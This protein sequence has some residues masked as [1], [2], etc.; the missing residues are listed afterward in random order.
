MGNWLPV[1]VFAQNVWFVG[2][3]HRQ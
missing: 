3:D 2:T 1:S